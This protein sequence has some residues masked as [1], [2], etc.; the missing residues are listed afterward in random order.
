MSY[1]ASWGVWWG[2]GLQRPA[3]SSLPPAVIREQEQ[4]GELEPGT[5]AQLGGVIVTKRARGTL[6]PE[7]VVSAGPYHLARPG[8]GTLGELY[9]SRWSLSLYKGGPRLYQA[10]AGVWV[11]RSDPDALGELT[12]QGVRHVAL[13]F[14]QAARPVLAWERDGAVYVRQWAGELARYTTRGPWAGCDPVLISDALAGGQ[15]P[16]S[17]VLLYHL[18][19]ERDAVIMRAQR[20]VYAV[21]YP[22][23]A[24]PPGSVLDQAV[25]LAYRV[26]LYGE[27]DRQSWAVVSDPYPVRLTERAAAR[28]SAPVSG[29]LDDVVRQRAAR[30][31]GVG[32]QAPEVTGGEL[33]DSVRQ[34][35]AQD[36]GVGVQAPEVTGGALADVVR[37]R[38]AQDAGVGV[39]AAQVAGGTLRAVVITASGSDPGC[40]VAISGPTG[41]R[42]AMKEVYV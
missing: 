30:D 31:A 2:L 26:Q 36:V 38:A 6:R 1:G 28:V 10:Q 39:Q 29:A 20:D 13:A 12:A 33:L 24:V 34:R 17:D 37:Q 14:D 18:N 16:G 15:V 23:A 11:D 19:P 3:W 35:A 4:R 21:A 41:G 8:G 32:A 40:G 5:A 27:A 9:G 25:T 42:L 22:G 7:L